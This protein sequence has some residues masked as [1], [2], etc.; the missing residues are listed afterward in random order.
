MYSRREALLSITGAAAAMALAKPIWAQ[1]SPESK[2]SRLGICSDSY[3][4]RFR[5][6]KD[7]GQDK[8]RFTEPLEFLDHCHRL[9]AGGIQMTVGRRGKSPFAAGRIVPSG[10]PG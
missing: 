1:A 5:A 6:N 2:S 10:Y 7:G 9:G 3:A 8:E 4:L